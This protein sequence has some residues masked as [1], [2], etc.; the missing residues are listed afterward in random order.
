MADEDINT[1]FDIDFDIDIPWADPKI[2]VEYEAALGAFLVRFNRIENFI[3]DLIGRALVRHGRED[4]IER[5]L[6]KQLNARIEI[7]EWLL[8]PMPYMS[9]VPTKRIQALADQRA[10]L[11][12]GHFEQNPF[13]GEYKIVGKGQSKAW[14]PE[15]IQPLMD[16]AVAICEELS[17]LRAQFWFDE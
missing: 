4:L 11:A 16:E 5:A 3:S 15:T 9:D 7:L 2:Q 1:A 12:H 13:S 10:S 17:N 14:T 6:K 8:V